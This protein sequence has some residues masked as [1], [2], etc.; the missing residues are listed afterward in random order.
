VGQSV[1]DW[2]EGNG[3][4]RRVVSTSPNRLAV[5]KFD[6]VTVDVGVGSEFS[7]DSDLFG[8]EAK[9]A[10]SGE[11]GEEIEAGGGEKDFPPAH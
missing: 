5:V 2:S 11:V 1:L 7:L 4:A 6:T 10:G 3:V 8:T 9:T